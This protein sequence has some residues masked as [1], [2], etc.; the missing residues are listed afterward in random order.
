MQTLPLPVLRNPSSLAAERPAP[1]E[2]ATTS[3]VL[4]AWRNVERQVPR[5]AELTAVVQQI[6][7]VRSWRELDAIEH[8]LIMFF[9]QLSPGARLILAHRW[10]VCASGDTFATTLERLA[11]ERRGRLRRAL[12]G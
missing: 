4:A 9:R 2:K 11:S 8:Q 12:V 5:D 3:S 7:S 6:P 10:S 1:S